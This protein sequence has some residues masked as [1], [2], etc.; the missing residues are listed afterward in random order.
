MLTPTR[1][2]EWAYESRVERLNQRRLRTNSNGAADRYFITGATGFIG[3]SLVRRLAHKAPN[4]TLCTP[5]RSYRTVS[6][7]ATQRVVMPRLDLLDYAAVKKQVEGS[8]YV[9][10]LAYSSEERTAHAINVRATQNV[11]R[12]ATEC[13]AEAVVVLSTMYVYGHPE[14]TGFVDETWP[15]CPAG[16]HYGRTK[17]EMQNWC[18]EWAR[19]HTETRLVLLNPSC[20]FGPEG[21]TYVTLPYDLACNNRFYWLDRGQGIANYVYIDNLLDAIE[22]ALSVR[23]AHG[24]NFLIT[25]GFCTWREFLTPLLLDKANVCPNLTLHEL[26]TGAFRSKTTASDLVRYL[27]S[28][29]AFVDL[30]NRHPV[31][32]R[33]KSQVFRRVPAMRRRL[34]ESRRIDAA[35]TSIV[36][37]DRKPAF[38]PPLWLADLFG[39]TAT[40][41]SAEKAALLLGWTPQV[42]F[43][44]AMAKTR[45]WLTEWSG[46]TYRP[47][48]LYAD[49]IS[50]HTLL[51]R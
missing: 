51:Q 5:V 13:A 34:E 17:V 49:S 35:A 33:L 37:T 19:Q 24:Q 18:L 41:F 6:S 16:G 27:L 3:A 28:D 50:H 40:R 38:D 32:G 45:G 47:E 39:P 20:V 48:E 1:L 43:D 9:L 22:Q 15:L 10:H 30:V 23:E 44:I 36:P 25:D 21:K 12:A 42:P 29:Y 7:I 4:A 46:S 8:R 2:L 11:V 26:K 31:L 14:T